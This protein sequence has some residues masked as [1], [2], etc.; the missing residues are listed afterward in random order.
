M[1][2]RY[3]EIRDPIHDFVRLD[4]DERRVLDS[5]PLQ[6]LRHIHQLSL[7]HLLYSGATHK[8]FEHSLGVTELAGRVFDVV[9]DTHNVTDDIRRRLPE[10]ADDDALRYWRRALRVAALCHD[11]GHLPFSHGA[12]ARLLPAG[13]SHE[14]LTKDILLSDQMT[15][16]FEGMTPPPRP[17]HVAKLAVG[18]RQAAKLEGSLDFTPWE[19][20]LSE[21]IVGDAFG[22]DR[23]DY[24]LR[25]S[26]HL[27]VAYGRFGHFRLM[28]T[29]RILP[30]ISGDE[31]TL[32]IDEGGI[33][34]AEALLL[35]R[36]YMFSQVYCHRVRRAYDIHLADFLGE[37]LLEGLPIEPRA[38]LEITDNEV[39]AALAKAARDTGARGHLAACR[40]L[41]RGHFRLLYS[42]NPE[43]LRV[44]PNPARAIFKAAQEA[45]GEDLVRYDSY[46]QG[47]GTIDFPVLCHDGRV[48]SAP[49]VSQVVARL[50]VLVIDYV[51]IDPSRREEAARWLHQNRDDIIRIEEEEET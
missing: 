33:H 7:S 37:W 28:D 18:P 50:P 10:I 23:M 25:D 49:S 46:E 32:G 5:P 22:V 14:R 31:P 35:A 38:F 9:T 6:R 27:G 24:L 20:I 47:S 41:E 45:F 39:L 44:N 51:F 19:A 40:I 11:I 16:L 36:Y 34:T 21:I 15:K 26:H 8:R 48:E 12:E 13:W 1:A 43:D 42:R 17:E 29:L 4:S 30:S 2:K 3:H